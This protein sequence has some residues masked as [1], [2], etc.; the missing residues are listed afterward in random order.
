MII[1]VSMISESYPTS[2]SQGGKQLKIPPLC[3]H[4]MMRADQK[5]C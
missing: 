4:A 2:L 3:A 1:G 5:G